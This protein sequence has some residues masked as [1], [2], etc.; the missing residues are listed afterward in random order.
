M[1]YDI[2][3][4]RSDI[5]DDIAFMVACDWQDRGLEYLDTVGTYCNPTYNY[6]RFFQAFHVRPTTDLHGRSAI[7]VKDMLDDALKE[8]GK[9][10]IDELEQKYFLDNNGKVISWGSIP[11]A[12]QWLRDVRDYCERN[13]C[14]KFLGHDAGEPGHGSAS[15]GTVR[16]FAPEYAQ[17][18]DRQWRK[19]LEETAELAAVGMDWVAD[20]TSDSRIYD[21][22]VEEYC[23]V[24]EA[25]GTFAIAYGITDEDIRKGMGE[26]EK[27]FR[28]GDAGGRKTVEEN[29]IIDGLAE[30]STR[31]QKVQGAM[32][33]NRKEHQ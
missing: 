32:I 1:S 12:I 7:V 27:R 3:I 15:L 29:T 26:C 30:L 23:D 19:L 10:S 4:V 33:A 18:S 16:T 22:L 5:P 11:N 20:G 31:L 13:P 6:V 28:D 21:R 14:Y 17:P 25:L 9:H 2:A 24:V 8:I